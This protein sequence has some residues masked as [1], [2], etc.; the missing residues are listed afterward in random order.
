MRASRV[1]SIRP[2]LLAAVVLVACTF[3]M[4]A[5]RP[6]LEEVHVALILLLVVL[7]ASAAGGRA[8][9]LAVAAASSVIFDLFFLAPYNTLRIANPLDWLVL[10]AF[11]TTSIVAAQLL[12]R[13]QEEA[14]VARARAAEIDYLSGPE[15]VRPDELLARFGDVPGLLAAEPHR[16]DVQQANFPS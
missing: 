9:G 15:H 16:V 3:G 5:V 14:R 10:V 6:L 2:L 4:V 8:L 7:G 11:F 12:Y 1:R 13:S